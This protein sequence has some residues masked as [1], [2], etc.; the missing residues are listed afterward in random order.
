VAL[1]KLKRYSLVV[2]RRRGVTEALND[3][4]AAMYKLRQQDA[5]RSTTEL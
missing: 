2:G 4:A 5:Q 1:R 3:L